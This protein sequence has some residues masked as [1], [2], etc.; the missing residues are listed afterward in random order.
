MVKKSLETQEKILEAARNVFTRK[1]M[2]GARM[3]EIAD[4]AGINKALLHY[5]Y[6]S[7][8]KL[9]DQ[10]FEEARGKLFFPLVQTLNAEM[11][12][13]EKIETICSQYYHFLKEYPYLPNF[14]IGEVYRTPEIVTQQMEL[15]GFSLEQFRVQVE[16]EIA[17]G[18]I[19]PIDPRE[20]VMNLIAL[21]VFP[22]MVRPIAE[23]MIYRDANYDEVLEQRVK[24]A[25]RFVINSI[26]LPQDCKE[27]N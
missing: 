18:R 17:A 3:Q 8:A 7:K 25:A 22:V 16:Q 15:A 24:M 4:E 21:N 2:S 19:R 13:F 10:I 6:R 11:D 1:G 9:F 27:E 20:L 14:V 26:A 23:N 5:Y 12:L